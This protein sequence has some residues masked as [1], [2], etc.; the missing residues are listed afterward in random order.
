MLDE[1]VENRY[2]YNDGLDFFINGYWLMPEAIHILLGWGFLSIFCLLVFWRASGSIAFKFSLLYFSLALYNNP[3]FNYLG[4]NINEYFGVI[5]IVFGAFERHVYSKRLDF[6]SPVAF[7]LIFLFLF[8]IVH[9]LIV[10]I[11]NPEL[12]PDIK[13]WLLKV[14]INFKVFIL[15]INL[16][17]V[18]ASARQNKLFDFI[19]RAVVLC[20]SVGAIIY[21]IQVGLILSGTLPFGT[22]FD[23]GFVGVPSFG[24][25]SIERGH[26]GKMMAP[27]APFFLYAFIVFK[28][29]IAFTL[30][31]I[32]SCIN[33]S[34]SSL[35][36]F[37]IF[38]LLATWY[39]RE[40]L[41][42]LR[43]FFIFST[44]GCA[45]V[46]LI[47]LNYEIY[48]GVIAKIYE[49]AVAG[50]EEG[51]G[52]RT[53]EILSVYITE[54]PYGIGYSGSTLRIAPG[55]PEINSGLYSFFSQFSFLG[56]GILLGYAYLLLKT[57][58]C[59][60]SDDR[61]LTFKIFKIG[62]V[63]SSFI[64]FADILWFIPT[65][66]LSYILIWSIKKTD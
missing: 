66:W 10:G 37:F 56:F 44:V 41:V 20:G 5:A 30:F 42:S 35:F 60:C 62:V 1:L 46:L 34:A 47:A 29:R 15:A 54:Y 63:L 12:N 14:A 19:I 65:I 38:C 3:A 64:F 2:P 16:L 13:T 8:S 26:F 25:V 43:N 32:V 6:R 61:L 31:F 58:Q 4:V 24:S 53:I 55:L 59:K 9:A 49:L 57:L 18:G 21:L 48:S 22:Y 51:V 27:L 50:D 28:W 36:F 11:F 39:F 40:Q 45:L 33:I 7:G 17:I 23:A 52:G